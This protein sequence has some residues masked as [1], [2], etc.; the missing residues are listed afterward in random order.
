MQTTPPQENTTR[1][2]ILVVEDH[3]E[4]RFFLRVA[5]EDSYDIDEA[6]SPE[7]ALEAARQRQFDALLIDISLGSEVDGVDLARRLRQSSEYAAT[8]MVA[9]TAHLVLD[10]GTSYLAKGFDEFLGKPFRVETLR[11]MLAGLV[12]RSDP[13]ETPPS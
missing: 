7:E 6:A 11:E 5:L 8:P 13:A 2:A 4:T 9:M 12:R 10:R 3:Q 1:P